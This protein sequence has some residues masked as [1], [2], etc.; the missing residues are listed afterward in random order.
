MRKGTEEKTP[1]VVR[2]EAVERYLKEA[3]GDSARNTPWRLGNST[4][5]FLTSN[6]DIVVRPSS[7]S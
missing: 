7:S 5:K 6:N 1:I 4:T 3:F 2:P